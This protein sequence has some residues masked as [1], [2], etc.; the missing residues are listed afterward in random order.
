MR[1]R[2][3]RELKTNH[4][5]DQ[6]NRSSKRLVNSDNMWVEMY[7]LREKGKVMANDRM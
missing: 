1:Y 2:L 4:Q 5:H 3:T 6:D 7:I